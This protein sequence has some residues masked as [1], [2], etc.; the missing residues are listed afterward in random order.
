MVTS[1]PGTYACK[2]LNPGWEYAACESGGPNASVDFNA[3]WSLRYLQVCI[4]AE[5][6]V[7]AAEAQISTK[8]TVTSTAAVLL[9]Q[10]YALTLRVA[11]N[12]P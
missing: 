8:A 2:A 9:L 12:A 10:E 6:C 3:S 5:G 7:S 1:Y 4:C 11:L